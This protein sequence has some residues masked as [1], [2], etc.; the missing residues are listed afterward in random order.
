MDIFK[1][2]IFQTGFQLFG[3]AIS[4]ISTLLVLFL[5]TRNYSEETTGVF[6]LTL[7]FLGFFF[8]AADLGLNAYILP[9]LTENKLLANKLYELRL[10]W[11]VI[12]TV[13]AIQTAFILPINNSF[14]Y[15]MVLLGS[16]I[17][18]FSGIINSLSLIFQSRLRYDLSVLAFSMGAVAS[19]LVTFFLIKIGVTTPYLILGSLVGAIINSIIGCLLVLKLYRFSFK[20]LDFSFVVETFKSAWPISLSL[21]LNVVYFRIDSFIL[22]SSKSLVDVGVYNLA[23]QFFQTILVIPTFIMNGFYPLMIKSLEESFLKF[24][25]QLLY[26]MLALFFLAVLI[27]TVS[28]FSA[29]LLISIFTKG[30]FSDSASVL[31]ILAISFPAFFVS[32][33]LMWCFVALKKYKSMLGIYLIGLLTNLFLNLFYIPKY[34]Y[35]GAAYT[36]VFS[37]YLILSLQ[38]VVLARYFKK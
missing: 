24:K 11:S 2:V 6:T 29:D 31:K 28:F 23:Y 35:F 16:P 8:L 1:K 4:S 17:I 3:K 27:T 9:K 34:S 25:K 22:A 10:V 7:T 5:I 33:L 26:A 15:Q 12:L 20:T 21:I 13:L 37:E 36:T 30:K 14:F 32:S 38:I 18:I 19:V